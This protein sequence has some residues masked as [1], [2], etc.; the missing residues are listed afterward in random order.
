MVC[1]LRLNSGC[2]GGGGGGGAT[3]ISFAVRGLFCYVIPSP[4]CP[5]MTHARLNT[6]RKI[7]AVLWTLWRKNVDYNPK[8]FC[9]IDPNRSGV[10]RR[11]VNA[12]L[13]SYR[14]RIRAA[15]KCSIGHLAPHAGSSS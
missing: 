13:R 7:L 11:I 10:V 4:P 2:G 8:L 14:W 1:S 15:G 3:P 5:F 12:A 9:F 6:Q